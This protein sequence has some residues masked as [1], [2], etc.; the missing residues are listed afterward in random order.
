MATAETARGSK[1]N[2]LKSDEIIQEDGAV[3]TG[4]RA[5]VRQV[6]SHDHSWEAN[7]ALRHR[8]F[9]PDGWK[10]LV[11]S[12]LAMRLL[13]AVAASIEARNLFPDPLNG[14][15]QKARLHHETLRRPLAQLAARRT[16]QTELLREVVQALNATGI[17]PVLLKGGRYLWLEANPTRTMRDLDFLVHPNNASDAWDVLISLGFRPEGPGSARTNRHHMPPMFREG[18][19]G[20]IE[21]HRRAG[22]PYAEQ[23][24]TTTEIREQSKQVATAHGLALLPTTAHHIWH[25]LVHHQFGHSGFARGRLELKGLHEFATA[26]REASDEDWQELLHLAARSGLAW[27]S[28][29]LWCAACETGLSTPLRADGNGRQD[30]ISSHAKD[31]AN[32]WLTRAENEEVRSGVYP[33]YRELLSLVRKTSPTRRTQPN[34]TKSWLPEPV[35]TAIMLAPKL[36]RA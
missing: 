30:W 13:P 8:L 27:S 24:L 15:M 22:N 7:N 29:E 34:A 28:L 17:K 1:G 31:L 20:W 21:L 11:R 18:T 9:D 14:R 23:F 35:K 3:A 5:L 25:G 36:R 19:I 10:L 4:G 12:A 6:I 16:A 32:I 2:A 26:V 33:G